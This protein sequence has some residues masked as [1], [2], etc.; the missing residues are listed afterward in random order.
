MSVDSSSIDSA[1]FHTPDLAPSSSGASGGASEGVLPGPAI[2]ASDSTF[3]GPSIGSSIDVSH[4]AVVED[5]ATAYEE[6]VGVTMEMTDVLSSD[7]NRSSD[8]TGS[9]ENVYH[10]DAIP[11]EVPTYSKN[12]VAGSSND[13]DIESNSSQA[14]VS[15]DESVDGLLAVLRLRR[16]RLWTDRSRR[17]LEYDTLDDESDDYDEH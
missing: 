11:D 12:Y 16:M 1:M 6:S 3:F 17:D 13:A 14:L 2:N 8:S 9:F 10:A 5:T 4:S 15:T 7:S